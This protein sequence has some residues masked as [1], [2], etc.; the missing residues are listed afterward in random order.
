MSEPDNIPWWDADDM[1]R[2]DPVI[3][4]FVEDMPLKIERL[5]ERL[6]TRRDEALR[7][8]ISDEVGE[9]IKYYIGEALHRLDADENGDLI[10]TFYFHP[11]KMS[12]NEQMYENNTP[13]REMLEFFLDT[14]DE[15]HFAKGMARA[16]R[17]LDAWDEPA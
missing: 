7:K 12:P 5:I 14:Y 11:E 4:K 9:G 13:L 6:I 8:R 17:L 10:A 1:I 3:Q 2:D 16:R 15:P